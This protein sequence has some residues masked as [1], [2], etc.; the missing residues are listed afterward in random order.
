MFRA[1]SVCS[2]PI[3][4]AI[5]A[6]TCSSANAQQPEPLTSRELQQLLSGNTLAGN[7]KVADPQ[8][9]YDWAAYYDTNGKLTLRHKPGSNGLIMRG[10]WWLTEDGQQCRKFESG[11]AQE[12]CWHFFRN[13]KFLRFVPTRGVAV[14]GRAIMLKENPFGLKPGF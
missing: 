4:I 10:Q 3:A 6:I 9:P 11:H 13:G 7:G 8:K 1:Q 5:V 2:S 14:E 12:G